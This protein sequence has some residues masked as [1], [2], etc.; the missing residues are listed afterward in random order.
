MCAVALGH[1]DRIGI[2]AHSPLAV[3]TTNTGRVHSLPAPLPW[4]D[5]VKFATESDKRNGRDGRNSAAAKA[6]GFDA[7]GLSASLRSAVKSAGYTEPTPIQR[8][9]IPLVLAGRDVLGCA[10]TGTGKTAAFALPILNRLLTAERR[11]GRPLIR[12]LVLAPTRELAAQIGESFRT[13]ARGSRLRG[14][15]VFGGVGKGPQISALRKGVEVLVATPGRLLDLMNMGEIDLGHVRYLVL[16]EADRML[17]MGFIH[18]V[19]RILK[20]VPRERQTMLYSATL[21]QEIRQL[22][23]SILSDPVRVAVDPV[24][25]TV[26]P[27]EQS[28]YFINSSQKAEFLLKLLRGDGIDRALVFTRTKHRANGLAKTLVQG[29]VEA[30][31][32]HGNKSQSARERALAGFKQG[33]IRVVVA[34]D[35]ASRGIDVKNLSHVINFDLPVDAESYVHRVG[36]TGRAGKSG[37]ALSLCSAE[38]RPYLSAIERLSRR[39]LDRPEAPKGFGVPERAS[40]AGRASAGSRSGRARSSVR[41]TAPRARNGRPGGKQVGSRRSR[42]SA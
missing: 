25:S 2:R 3:R 5:C 11:P 12:T 34:T 27:I 22:A 6:S 4:V 8:E 26:E 30:D 32:I 20:A 28:V 15:V 24:Y 17:D 23:G 14:L 33:R 38:E 19:R 13:Y 39:R 16:D 40:A 7:L 31:A 36:R 37:V 9:T 21:P 1:P 18:D 35:I 41:S 29:G 10:Q 42:R